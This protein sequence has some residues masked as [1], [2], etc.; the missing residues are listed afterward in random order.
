MSTQEM[1]STTTTS[2]QESR[3]KFSWKEYIILA[4][5]GLFGVIVSLPT[6]WPI[7]EETATKANIPV[8]LLLGG[9][10]VQSTIW[11]LVVVGI[12]LLLSTKIGLGAPLLRG[13]LNGDAVG[14]K[15]RS[16]ILSSISLGVLGA[17][18]A[19]ALEVWFFVPRMPGFSSVI[20]QTAG[21]KGFLAALYGG[22]TEEILSRLFLLTLLAWVLSWFS[23]LEDQRP[24]PTVMWIAIFGSAVVFGLGHLPATLVTNQF[25][26]MILVRAIFL[27][28]IPATIFGYLYWKRGLESS[29]M[30]HF[31]ADLVVHVILPLFS[32]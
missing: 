32:V 28:G 29:I 14:K 1:T 27:N 20:S 2:T 26:L 5:A 17:M 13:Y 23:H 8:Q 25:S 24:S 30:A 21:W 15:F 16:H 4:A 31:S 12:G 3:K 10:I 19:K 7:L 18:T 22:I 6:M 9:Q 11:M